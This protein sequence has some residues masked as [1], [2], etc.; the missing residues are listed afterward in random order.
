M[1]RR[2][3]RILRGLVWGSIGAL[4]A[5]FADPDRGRSRR[6][7]ARDQFGGALRRAQRQAQRRS[8]HMRAEVEGKVERLT[9]RTMTAPADDR[10][11]VDRIKSQVLSAPRF[12]GLDV[13]VEAVNGVITL[14]G[15]VDEH[16]SV[17]DL[18]REIAC[19]PGVVDVRS[20]L[21]EPGTPAPNKQASLRAVSE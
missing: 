21:H 10:A 16:S 6:T 15:Q 5:Y 13:L 4:G 2:L 11:L 1:A 9:H 3:F 17:D 12:T 14:R 7:R 20:F 19:V 8:R 18:E